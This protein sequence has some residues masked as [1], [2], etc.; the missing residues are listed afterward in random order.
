MWVKRRR[1][2]VSGSSRTI[3]ADAACV[4]AAHVRRW[5]VAA[6][7]L[8]HVKIELAPDD[9]GD[10]QDAARRLRQPRDALPEHLAHAL[11]R[12]GARA[13]SRLRAAE[14][15][16]RSERARDLLDEERVPVG[17]RVDRGLELPRRRAAARRPHQVARLAGREPREG[18]ARARRM[19]LRERERQR[20]I[21]SDLA[22]AVG[23]EE[24]DGPS[25][26]L[27]RDVAEQE[28][29]RRVGPVQIVDRNEQGLLAR[30]RFEDARHA[31]EEREAESPRRGRAGDPDLRPLPGGASRAPRRRSREVSARA[32]PARDRPGG[33]A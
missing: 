16:L 7:P 6:R 27:A 17:S 14:R 21:R 5:R 10:L 26:E 12:A 15:S 33:S 19:E 3:P 4:S 30:R 18:Q 9:R 23:A 29:G 22:V 31:L 13:G 11:R 24:H 20:M 25:R 28:E 32:P 2:D 1:P 8:E